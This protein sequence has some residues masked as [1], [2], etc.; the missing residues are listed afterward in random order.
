LGKS[1]ETLL[2]GVSAFDPMTY[3]IAA[4]TLVAAGLIAA[5]LPAVRASRIDPVRALRQE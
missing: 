5:T 3:A 1:L 4:L 2:F